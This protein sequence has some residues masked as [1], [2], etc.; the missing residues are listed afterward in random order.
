MSRLSKKLNDNTTIIY[1]SDHAV[2]RFVQVVDKR[3]IERNDESDGY[4]LDWNELF[5]YS[6]N[7]IN[8]PDKFF[9]GFVDTIS[10]VESVERYFKNKKP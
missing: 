3:E 8:L 5:G 4:I 9:A 10:I 7:K 2:G 1:G 6:N